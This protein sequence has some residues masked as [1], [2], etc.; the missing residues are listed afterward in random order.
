MKQSWPA[1]ERTKAPLLAVL[2]RVLPASGSLLEVASGSGQ[3]AAHFARALPGLR[4]L[5]SDHDP[6]N[7]ASIR[8]W[9][10]ESGLPNLLPPIELDVRSQRWDVGMLDAAF[11]ANMI[12]IAPGECCT[13]LFAGLGRHLTLGAIFVLYGP[14]RIA[15]T[16]TAPSNAEFDAGLRARDP[17]WGVRDIEAV[18]AEAAQVGLALRERV[19]MPANNQSLVFV[20]TRA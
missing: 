6:D 2:E 3:H 13:G 16:H 1:P 17:S 11:N 18:E 14:F 10:A 9:V 19:A 20:R 5:P 8:A 7:L 15:G 4:W 12:H